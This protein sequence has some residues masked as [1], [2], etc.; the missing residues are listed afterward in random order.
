MRRM[1]ARSG[2]LG[3]VL[4]CG[5]LAAGSIAADWAS[6][7][8][9]ARDKNTS[10]ESAIQDMTFVQEMNMK[11]PQGPVP[12]AITV[13]KKGNKIRT[14]STVKMPGMPADASSV[15]NVLIYDGNETWVSSPLMGKQ[16][17]TD[18][19]HHSGGINDWCTMVSDQGKIVGEETINDR[20]CYVAEVQSNKEMPFTKLWIDKKTLN[21]VKGEALMPNGA[22]AIW[23]ASDFRPVEGGWEI[24][25][26]SEMYMG[27][28][29]VSTSLMKSFT[30]NS[31]LKEDLF[32]PQA[33]PDQKVS[34]EDIMK[35]MKPA[36]GAV[37]QEGADK[38][39]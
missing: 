15:Q 14:E 22:T 24:P 6:V 5:F 30:V 26:K 36:Q 11:G 1:L 32:N 17:L 9:E 23:V 19:R 20:A 12:Q 29:L 35:R 27:K 3:V 4:A 33:L 7:V 13:Y 25:F 16:K 18:S 34:M 10:F 8:K 28:D 21:M 39:K 38:A 2:V 31:G 37:K